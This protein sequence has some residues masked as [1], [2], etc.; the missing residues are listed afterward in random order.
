M[1]YYVIKYKRYRKALQKYIWKLPP[2]SWHKRPGELPWRYFIACIVLEFPSDE[3]AISLNTLP[4]CNMNVWV[5]CYK[6]LQMGGNRCGCSDVASLNICR[7]TPGLGFSIAERLS[8]SQGNI[9]TVIM[10]M[11]LES[12]PPPG[13]N[14]LL[15]ERW[16]GLSAT[17]HTLSV[18]HHSLCQLWTTGLGKALVA[19]YNMPGIQWT[20]SITQAL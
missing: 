19:S 7:V 6:H 13:H 18:T 11:I 9:E 5:T 8:N 16:H 4:A 10:M 15:Y 14:A 1:K 20:Y 12:N 17:L 3:M 2:V